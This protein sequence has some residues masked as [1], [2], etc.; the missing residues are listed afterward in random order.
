M[1]WAALGIAAVVW[2]WRLKPA[3]DPVRALGPLR[4]LFAN[5]FYVD[6][7]QNALVVRPVTALARGV[8]RADESIVDGAVEAT[9]RGTFGLGGLVAAAHRA[10]LPRAV[11]AV[12]GG[13]ALLGLAAV[14]LAEV[15]S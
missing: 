11:T 1:V 8:R 15:L 5:A 12:L 9:G 10:G 6:A 7:L 3:D 14:A 4:S 2:I 13:A